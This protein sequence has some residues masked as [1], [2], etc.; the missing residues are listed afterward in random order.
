MSF[1]GSG[2]LL[3]LH[4]LCVHVHTQFP[5]VR[6]HQFFLSQGEGGG[7]GAVGGAQGWAESQDIRCRGREE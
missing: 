7:S 2:N 1:R 5:G 3:I 6:I 4:V